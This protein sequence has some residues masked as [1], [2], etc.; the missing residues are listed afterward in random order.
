MSIF[1]LQRHPEQLPGEVYLGNST[2]EDA[3]RIGWTTKR[4]GVV[5]IDRD[6]QPLSQPSRWPINLRY[7]L[8]PWFAQA[9]EID[10]RHEGDGRG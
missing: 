6:G 2:D 4:A 10:A 5:A 8:R 9:Q 7:T 3:E 1:P